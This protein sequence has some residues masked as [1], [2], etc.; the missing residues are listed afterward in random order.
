[1]Q[2]F[3]YHVLVCT[4]AKPENVRSCAAS[5]AGAIVGA[6]QNELRAQRLADDVIVS[7]T[8]CLGGCENGPIVIVYPDAVWY[9]AVTPADVAEIVR[10]HLGQGKPVDRLKLTDMDA[11]RGEILDH[12][13]KFSAIVQ[14]RDTAGVLPDEINE[15][16]RA[17]QASRVVLTAVELDLFTAVGSGAGAPEI[18]AELRTDPRATE[19]LLNAVTALGLIEKRNGT[20]ANTPMT[21]RFLVEGS[22][23]NARWALM[24]TVHLWPRWSTLTECVREGTAVYRRDR[25]AQLTR[26]FISAMDRIAKEAA[27]T[28]VRSLPINSARRMLDLGGGSGAYSIALARAN[29]GLRAEVLDMPEVVPLAQE[30]IREAGLADRV[31]TRTGDLRTDQFGQGYD[32]I[33]LGAICHMF[34]PEQNRDLLR[35]A[36][37]ALAPKGRLVVRDFIL[38]PDKTSPR[39]AALFSLNMLVG[40]EGGAS[41]SEPEYERWL[42]DAGFGD[43][44]RVR[45]PGPGNLMVGTRR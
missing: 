13:Q 45:L 8:G 9:G 12:R 27:P 23:D 21:A 34:T 17:F 33:L 32:L 2:P 26:A 39:F 37:A 44:E 20:F 19:M 29:P 1:M 38:D 15:M 41:Y 31:S 11:L 16:A 30:Y 25:N 18:A 28:M 40:T 14:A 10:S 7:T 35:R 24:H 43:V 36:F 5:G 42:R 6:L 22:P 3:R 4:Q